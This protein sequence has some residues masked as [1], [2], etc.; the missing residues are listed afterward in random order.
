MTTL[1][2]HILKRLAKA[3]AQGQSVTTWARHHDVDPETAKHASLQ[4]EFDQLVFDERAQVTSQLTGKLV[5]HTR[6]TIDQIIALAR[7][8]DDPNVKLSAGRMIMDYW[9]KVSD[10]LDQTKKIDELTAKLDA[11]EA[12]AKRAR[13]QRGLRS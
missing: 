8:S 9:L 13:E 4:P 10:L 11:W 12:R 5:K 2:D 7:Y 3:L 1:N 6:S